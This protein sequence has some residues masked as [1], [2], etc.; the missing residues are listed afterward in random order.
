MINLQQNEKE[1]TIAIAIAIVIVIVIVIVIIVLVVANWK[2]LR[3]SETRPHQAIKLSSH[4]DIK[5]AG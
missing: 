1:D 2:L 4:Q 5:L 3:L